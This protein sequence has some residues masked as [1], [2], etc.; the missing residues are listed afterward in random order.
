M[1]TVDHTVNGFVNFLRRYLR[2][3]TAGKMLQPKLNFGFVI[4]QR[5]LMVFF[6]Q[7]PDT[8][9]FEGSDGQIADLINPP[10]FR[11]Q[12][13][14]EFLSLLFVPRAKRSPNSFS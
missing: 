11:L 4:I 5:S 14:V 3:I 1:L 12:L 7:P 13:V 2:D 6:A 9:F 10:R 8:A